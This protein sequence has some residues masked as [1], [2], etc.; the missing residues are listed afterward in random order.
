MN[1]I[2]KISQ[3]LSLC[4]IVLPALSGCIVVGNGPSTHLEYPAN[5]QGLGVRSIEFISTDS[6]AVN[7]NG[8]R[9]GVMY[10]NKYEVTCHQSD[11]TFYVYWDNDRD[12]H[13]IDWRKAK[14]YVHKKLRYMKDEANSKCIESATN[15]SW[16]IPSAVNTLTKYEK[17]KQMTLQLEQ[18]KSSSSDAREYLY[19]LK[20][21]H[22]DNP[23]FD[24]WWFPLQEKLLERTQF[25]T[26]DVEFSKKFRSGY[27]YGKAFRNELVYHYTHG[28]KYTMTVNGMPVDTLLGL[29]DS[30]TPYILDLSKYDNSPFSRIRV[31]G[32]N[33]VS[34]GQY[35]QEGFVYGDSF[36]VPSKLPNR[37]IPTKQVVNEP[38]TTSWTTIGKVLIGAELLRQGLGY[39]ASHVCQDGACD[40]SSANRDEV[41][42]A[43]KNRNVKTQVNKPVASTSSKPRQTKPKGNGG[44]VFFKD[45]GVADNKKELYYDFKCGNG[46][47]FGY[48][49][50][51]K[52]K[53]NCRIPSI[54]YSYTIERH[55]TPQQVAEKMCK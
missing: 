28:A 14:R 21:F 4:L 52:F 15:Q 20:L 25:L 44:V 46:A 54:I 2:T 13:S 48:I 26:K 30:P 3:Y 42:L 22:E 12:R 18:L 35:W 9:Q 6:A 19:K 27:I 10:Y 49:Y 41:N 53:S 55:L 31:I 23:H 8:V 24:F 47:R 33:S 16:D 11:N 45:L 38:K 34:N 29:D 1:L 37:I 7:Y 32:S 40:S 50:C 17:Y 39:V 51:D 43:N 36:G 5:W